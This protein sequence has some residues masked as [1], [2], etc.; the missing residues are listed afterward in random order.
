MKKKDSL[1]VFRNESI[2]VAVLKNTVPAMAAMMMVLIY[3]LADTFFISQTHDALMVAAISLASP[4]F[5]IFIAIGSIFGIGGTSVISRAMGE[6]RTEY[7]KNV[8]AFCTWGSVTAGIMFTLSLLVFMEP[9]LDFIGTSEDTLQ[10]TKQYLQI[11]ALTGPFVIVSN[12]HANIIRA[13]GKAG[14]AMAGQLIGNLLNIILDPILILGLGWNVAGAA[15]ATAIANIVSTVYYVLY[16][17]K[18]RSILSIDPR[19]FSIKDGVLTGV[20]SI[21]LPAAVGDV[22]MSISG[23]IINGKMA[24]YGDMA[25]AGIGIAM[26]VTMMKTSY[27]ALELAALYLLYAKTG[28]LTCGQNIMAF[29][30]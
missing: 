14:M 13:E 22:L 29:G 4:I 24:L 3:N 26:K 10:Y 11:I 15:G 5:M 20:L 6:G 1:E 21:G 17:G 18:G 28:Q 23:V 30:G 27:A 8:S 2:P 7:A 19:D 12:C 25:V 9:V 16:F